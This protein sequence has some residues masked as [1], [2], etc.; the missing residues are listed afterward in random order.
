ADLCA[1]VQNLL[2]EISTEIISG[3]VAIQPYRYKGKEPC[4]YCSYPAVCGFDP[5]LPGHSYRLLQPREAE[6]IWSKIRAARS[7]IETE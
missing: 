2:L 6:E 3:E 4:T 5:L 7:N 1:Y